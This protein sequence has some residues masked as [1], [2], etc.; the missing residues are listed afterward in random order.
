M[1]DSKLIVFLTL[2]LAYG[3]TS[4]QLEEI[5]NIFMKSYPN[6][7][8]KCRKDVFTLL[9]KEFASFSFLLAS[10]YQ[11]FLNKWNNQLLL[12]EYLYKENI[13]IVPKWHHSYPKRLRSIS[14]PF[15][16]FVRGDARL[17]QAKN[18][19]AMVGTRKP[20]R[21]AYKVGFRLSEIFTGFHFSIT[22]GL[23][24]GCDTA[25]HKGCLE[26]GGQTVAVL[27]HDLV[28]SVYPPQNAE[29]AQKISEEGG[30]VVSEYPIQSPPL[31]G[32]FVQ[33]NRLLVSLSDALVVIEGK[34]NS[35][36]SHS[37]N[38]AVKQK[39]PVGYFWSDNS[40]WNSSSCSELN[41]ILYDKDSA[42]SLSCQESIAAFSDYLKSN[43]S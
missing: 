7:D 12:T 13:Q 4:R 15:F 22:S 23:A 24:L 38:F 11:F 27:A 29:L 37:V 10:G 17:L 30:L 39:K 16:L 35:G 41:R 14:S 31:R 5:H 3:A 26:N 40:S 42:F 28:G 18:S 8:W 34:K 20:T 36:T 1:P 19:I 33:R 43:L 25:V 21:L 2:F 9:K 6:F 32:R